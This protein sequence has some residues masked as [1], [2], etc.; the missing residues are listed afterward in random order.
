MFNSN[1]KVAQKVYLVKNEQIILL[2]NVCKEF[3]FEG[4][5]FAWVHLVEVTSDTTVDNSDLVFN[6][7]WNCSNK[8]NVKL[9]GR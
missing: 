2:P 4:G 1:D 7:H 8:N 3:F 9:V 5:N 6:G